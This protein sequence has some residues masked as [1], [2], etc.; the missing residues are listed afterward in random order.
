MSDFSLIIIID[1]VPS[2]SCCHHLFIIQGHCGLP[3]AV[4]MIEGV[5]KGKSQLYGL[6]HG[7]TKVVGGC[8]ASREKLTTMNS[9]R[10]TKGLLWWC[11]Q[12]GK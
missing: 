11:N 4:M 7:R 3:S 12:P 5:Q 8:Q 10:H 9:Y 1:L 2:S 6:H